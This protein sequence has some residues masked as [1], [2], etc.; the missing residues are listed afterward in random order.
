MTKTNKILLGIATF[1][2]LV[3]LVV[4]FVF[5]FMTFMTIAAN[6]PESIEDNPSALVGSIAGVFV[7]IILAVLLGFGLMVY[8]I[9]HASRNKKFNE[10][11][12]VVWIVV[13][14]F[15]STVGSIVYF[16]MNIVPLEDPNNKVVG[17]NIHT[18][19]SS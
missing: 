17:L 14:I 10:T 12:R 6:G 9:I 19:E 5:F 1:L 7:F 11:E 15:A 13:L 8:Y 4:Y 2:P 16:F 18:D 3:F